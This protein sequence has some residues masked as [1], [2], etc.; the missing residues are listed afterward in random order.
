MTSLFV[1]GVFLRST[2]IYLRLQKISWISHKDM[3]IFQ[4]PELLFEE[5]HY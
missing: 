4:V 2:Y 3:T 1:F 5:S